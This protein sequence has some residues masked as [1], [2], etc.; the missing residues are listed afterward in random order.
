MAST[1][2]PGVFPP[3]R[4]DKSIYVDGGVVENT[5]L[6]PAIRAGATK[7]HAIYLDPH[8]RFIRLKGEAKAF[9]T[10]MRV[11]YS[12]VGNKDPED[13]ETARWINAGLDAVAEFQARGTISDSAI[14]DVI[15]VVGQLIT[16]N[17]SNYKRLIIHRYFPE[18]VL[19]EILECW[20]SKSNQSSA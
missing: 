4:I 12:D 7:L 14:R 8:P 19:G 9:K 15:R 16:K 5:P 3:V 18:T 6:N 1:A 11:Y 2:I 20:I 13:V 17:P 10:L